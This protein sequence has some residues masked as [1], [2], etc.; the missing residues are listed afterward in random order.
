MSSSPISSLSVKKNWRD[1]GVRRRWPV[2]TIR[3]VWLD[4]QNRLDTTSKPLALLSVQCEIIMFWELMLDCLTHMLQ[5]LHS[6]NLCIL[7]GRGGT[8]GQPSELRCVRQRSRHRRI[9]CFC[10]CGEVC[11]ADHG[12]AGVSGVHRQLVQLCETLSF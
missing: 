11:S 6:Q 7:P 8:P 5:P 10:I 3:S 2:M 9:C 12:G 1:E 4:T